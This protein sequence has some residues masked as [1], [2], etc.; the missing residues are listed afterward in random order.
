MPFVNCHIFGIEYS[1]ARQCMSR[2]LLA[3]VSVRELEEQ[4]GIRLSN[5]LSR[6]YVLLSDL[7]LLL[8][9]LQIFVFWG[10][11]FADGGNTIGSA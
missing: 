1:V 10:L 5:R 2:T 8:V 3:R 6:D 4:L 11:Y 9:I 7:K